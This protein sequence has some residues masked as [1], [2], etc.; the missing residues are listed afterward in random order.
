MGMVERSLRARWFQLH[1]EP[2]DGLFHGAE[3]GYESG[4]DALLPGSWPNGMGMSL[5]FEHLI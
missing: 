3:L 2:P 1:I 4:V 5:G